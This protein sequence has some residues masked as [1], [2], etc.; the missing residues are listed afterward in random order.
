MPVGRLIAHTVTGQ[1]FHVGGRKRPKSRP[2]LKFGDYV[3]KQLVA[4]AVG[5][6]P[7]APAVG[8]Y[9]QYALQALYRMYLNNRLGDCVAAWLAHQQGVWTGNSGAVSGGIQYTDDQISAFYTQCSGGEWNPND[10]STDQGCDVMQAVQSLISGPGFPNGDKVVAVMSVDATN[11]DEITKACWLFEGL[12]EGQELPASVTTNMPSANGFT[13]DAGGPPQPADGHCTGLVGWDTPNKRMTVS[14]WGMLG[15][16]TEAYCAKYLVPSAG[17]E[18]YALLS[19]D[20][21]SRATNKAAN[22]YDFDTLQA[23]IAALQN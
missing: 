10:P 21:I 16:Q 4:P 14:T 18:L 3:S 12:T 23:D 2:K 17:G 20:V 13:W 11:W 5:Q 15:Y 8:D 19:Q 22:G 1:L 6:V 7:C 9:S